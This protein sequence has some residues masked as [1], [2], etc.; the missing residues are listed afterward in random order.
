MKSSDTFVHYEKGPER[1]AAEPFL[2]NS[3]SV[4]MHQV[5]STLSESETKSDRC[6][7]FLYWKECRSLELQ[8]CL[9]PTHQSE[10]AEPY[11]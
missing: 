8:V 2:H 11:T 4:V 3:L 1:C 5:N 9:R 10:R 6:V 7:L